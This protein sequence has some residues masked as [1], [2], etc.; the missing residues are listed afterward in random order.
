LII[1]ITSAPIGMVIFFRWP[2]I[3]GVVA[4]RRDGGIGCR[5]FLA[6]CPSFA[7]TV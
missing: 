1:W 5:V 7:V 4:L 2:M 3:A 6:G